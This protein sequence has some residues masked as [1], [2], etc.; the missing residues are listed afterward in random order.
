MR[1]RT[2]VLQRFQ[3]G[4]NTGRAD[5]RRFVAVLLDR[6]LRFAVEIPEPIRGESFLFALFKNAPYVS[7]VGDSIQNWAW[8]GIET[9]ALRADW[10]QSAPLRGRLAIESIEIP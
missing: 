9:T 1:S 8:F 10:T 3:Q 6:H 2:V 7:F 4:A 5:Q